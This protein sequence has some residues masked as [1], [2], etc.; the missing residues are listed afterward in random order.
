VNYWHLKNYLR[1][2]HAGGLVLST[3]CELA[4]GEIDYRMA[5]E[6][7]LGAGYSGPLCLEHY[8]G[9]ALSAMKRGR[10]YLQSLQLELAA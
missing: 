7:V 4:A 6:I 5:L 2:R 9:D 10:E 3:P 8:G 1:L